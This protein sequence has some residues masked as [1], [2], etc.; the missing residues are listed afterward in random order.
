MGAAATITLPERIHTMDLKYPLM[1]VGTADKQLLVYNLTTIQQ[2]TNPYKA[3]PT[4]LKMQTR[5]VSCF[6][7]RTGFA[8]GSIEG[9]CSIVGIE[10]ASKNLLQVP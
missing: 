4:P 6:P 7:C 2:S 9:R 8:V 5:V 1:V 3:I 10:D